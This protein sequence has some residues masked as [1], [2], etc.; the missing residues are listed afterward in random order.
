MLSRDRDWL[1]DL[2]DE[3]RPLYGAIGADAPLVLRL[4]PIDR[5]EATRMLGSADLQR[6]VDLIER[7]GLVS[8]SGYPR[9]LT[10]LRDWKGENL[11][12]A[13]VW[14]DIL[15]DLVQEHDH[16]KTS[17]YR[18]APEERFEAVSRLAAVSLLA[19]VHE[20][21]DGVSGPILPLRQRRLPARAGSGARPRPSA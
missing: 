9:V 16:Q 1:K 7:H 14:Q 17:R 21:V 5:R 15:T 6:V 19:G 8:I 10:H 18:S 4:A 20:L 11:T 3:F 2:E 13:G 12:A